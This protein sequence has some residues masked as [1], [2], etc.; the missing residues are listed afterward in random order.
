MTAGAMAMAAGTTVTLYL[1]FRRRKKAEEEWSRARTLRAKPAQAP[2]NLFESIETLRFTY[3]ETIRKWPIADLAFDSVGFSQDHV[4]LHSPKVEVADSTL[5]SWKSKV[6]TCPEGIT[7]L[8]SEVVKDPL[9]VPD[10]RTTQPGTTSKMTGQH[11]RSLDESFKQ[12]KDTITMVGCS[13][14][15]ASSS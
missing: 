13:Q 4:L 11:L 10:S 2:A 14:Q 7:A 1:L 5:C 6:L 8:A 15:Q 9:P 3:S 12:S